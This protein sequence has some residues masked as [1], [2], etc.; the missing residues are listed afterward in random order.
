MADGPAAL[1]KIDR[2]FAAARI[3]HEVISDCT[4]GW[5]WRAAPTSTRELLDDA[6]R[7][8]TVDMPAAATAV[9][10]LVAL[11][12]EQDLLDP[13]AAVATGRTLQ[14]EVERAD[15][16]LADMRTRQHELAAGLRRRLADPDG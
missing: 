14:L 5:S 4:A 15:S 13:A 11:W 6:T 3:A 8:V 7:I 2:L 16:L 12:I 10:R 9:R 1:A